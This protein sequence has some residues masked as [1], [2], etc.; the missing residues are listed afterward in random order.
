MAKQAVPLNDL[1]GAPE[2]TG[3][4]GILQIQKC[5]LMNEASIDPTR[6]AKG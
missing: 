1:G 3:S 4:S 2:P 5:D 6:G